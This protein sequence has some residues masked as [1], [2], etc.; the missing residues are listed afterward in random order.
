MAIEVQPLRVAER[1]PYKSSESTV[2]SLALSI[3]SSFGQ[4]VV[5]GKSKVSSQDGALILVGTARLVD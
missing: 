4:T 5:G 1:G 2:Q 3:A